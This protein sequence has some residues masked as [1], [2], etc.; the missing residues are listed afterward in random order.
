[1]TDE[2]ILYD[3]EI[4]IDEIEQKEKKIAQ[5]TA[6]S[7]SKDAEIKSITASKDAEIAQLKKQLEE[8]QKN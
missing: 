4:L 8:L 7:D 1:M 6:I 5:I 3:V 2:T